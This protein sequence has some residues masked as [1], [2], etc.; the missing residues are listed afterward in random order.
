MVQKGPDEPKR[1]Q[2]G[3][4]HLGWTF[5]SPLDPYGPFPTKMIFLSQMDKVGVGRGASE[6]NINSEKIW[7]FYYLFDVRSG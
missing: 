7:K 4:K 3:Q 1:V 6:Q 2:N 5:W